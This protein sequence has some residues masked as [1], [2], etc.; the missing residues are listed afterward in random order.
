[1]HIQRLVDEHMHDVARQKLLARYER[2]IMRIWQRLLPTLGATSIVVMMQRAAELT[3]ARYP[4]MHRLIIHEEGVDMSHLQAPRSEAEQ[5]VLH[6]A[7]KAFIGHV[8]EILVA[9][10]GTVLAHKVVAAL[11]QTSMPSIQA[12]KPPSPEEPA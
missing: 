3:A 8:I 4:H 11:E 2:L 9:L 10:T 12:D 7:L 6:E 5:M 1:M